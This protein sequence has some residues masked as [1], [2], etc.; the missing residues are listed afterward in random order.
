[1]PADDSEPASP[2]PSGG[3][4][5]DIIVDAEGWPE[6]S[7]RLIRQAAATLCGVLGDEAAG[8]ATVVLADDATVQE[9]NARWRGKDMPTNVLSFPAGPGAEERFL[10]DVILARETVMREAT[11]GDLPPADHLRHLAIH[12]LLHL[13]G[14]D[15]EDDAEAEDMETLEAAILGELGIPNPY[16]EHGEGSQKKQSAA[17]R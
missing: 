14:Y 15:H 10:G 12:G 16:R 4:L 17:L 2:E 9:L 8:T 1:M 7:D 5:I 11:D 13:L 3:L 6:N